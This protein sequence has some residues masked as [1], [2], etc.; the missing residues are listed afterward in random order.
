MG[1]KN[2]SS[3]QGRERSLKFQG[4]GIHIAERATGANQRKQRALAFARWAKLP[5]SREEVAYLCV[6]SG[7]RE[8]TTNT[9]SLYFLFH[10]P[11]LR[12]HSSDAHEWWGRRGRARPPLCA[13]RWRSFWWWSRSPHPTGWRP[14]GNWIIHNSSRLVRLYVTGCVDIYTLA[15]INNLYLKL[16][17][18]YWT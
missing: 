1:T 17:F 12:I 2:S 14:M 4:K 16:I 11:S 15:S 18:K 10:R 9:R 8:Y 7:I 6:P 5:P 13:R 3:K